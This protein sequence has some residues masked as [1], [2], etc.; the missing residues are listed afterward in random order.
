MKISNLITLILAA[1]TPSLAAPKD[2]DIIVSDVPDHV[3]PYIL[4]K[5]RGRAIRLTP[6]QIV[7]Y[8]ITANSSGGAFSMIQHNGKDS[9]YPS[10][11]SH[12]HKLT[13]EHFYCSKGRVELWGKQNVTGASH[14]SRIGTIGDY[15]NIPPESI[16]TFQ[17]VDPDTQLTHVFHPAGFE[18]LFDVFTLGE[19]DTTGISSPYLPIPDDK[20]PFGPLT[21][22]MEALLNSLDLY[23]P[24]D[25]DY[26][27]RR[28]W[29]N[30]TAGDADLRWHDGPNFLPDSDVLPYFVAKDYG[31]K[32]LNSESGYKVIQPLATPDQATGGNFSMG[33]IIMSPNAAA[34]KPSAATLPHAFALQMEEGQ[35]VVKVKGFEEAT[36]HHGDV[37]FIPADVPFTYHATI[38][39]T[40][41]LYMNGGAEGLDFQLLKNAE[42]WGWPAYPEV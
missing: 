12:T 32:Y 14:E 18:H 8:S 3:R 34:E 6:S 19:W 28:D 11:R 5:Y 7:R 16:H 40:K 27:P 37:A 33:T 15:G 26:L 23:V 17:L 31:P 2:A 29:V 25:E 24:P 22:D 1:A 10:A 38:P 20:P 42:P 9:G 35:L 36:M 41:F 4:P 39:F 21:P 13:H 30:G